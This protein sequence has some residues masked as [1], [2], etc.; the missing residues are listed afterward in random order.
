VAGLFY[1]TLV[2]PPEQLPEHNFSAFFLENAFTCPVEEVIAP[3]GLVHLHV[4]VLWHA[5]IHTITPASKKKLN[6]FA[7][8]ILK[9]NNYLLVSEHSPLLSLRF[10]QDRVAVFADLSFW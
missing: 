6:F 9:F 10:S 7:F 3:S 8:I 5:L 1:L 2:V 4:Y